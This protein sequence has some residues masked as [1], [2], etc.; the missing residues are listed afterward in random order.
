MTKTEFIEVCNAMLRNSPVSFQDKLLPMFSDYLTEN[1]IENSDKMISLVVQNPQL[2]QQVFPQV[3][4]YFGKKFNVF[5]LNT[6]TNG[7]MNPIYY[8]E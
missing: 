3:I 8:Y 1:N 2:I 7:I 6:V 4:E 5:V